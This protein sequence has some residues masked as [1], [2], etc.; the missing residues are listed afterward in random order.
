[1]EGLNMK[2]RICCFTGH[3]RIAK[4]KYSEIKSKLKKTIIS[5]IE[6]DIICFMA[7]GALG[8]DTLAAQMVLELKEEYPIIRLI[9]VL[10]CENQAFKWNT[11]DVEIYNNIKSRCDKC[12]YISKNYTKNCM[13][14]RNHYLVDNSSVCVCYKNKNIGGTAYTVRY[15]EEKNLEIINVAFE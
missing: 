7:G 6:K 14:E 11:K 8:F 3:R 13:L 10:P 1:M 9:L 12:I 4:S 2:E 5:L 15:A